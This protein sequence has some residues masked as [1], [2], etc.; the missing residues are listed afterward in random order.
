MNIHISTI[1]SGIKLYTCD[2]KDCGKMFSE[3]GNL[4]IHMRTHNGE[5]P[6]NCTYC[7]KNFTSLGNMKDHERRH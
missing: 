6:Y 1:H 4:I 7:N 3:K 5:K 2:L